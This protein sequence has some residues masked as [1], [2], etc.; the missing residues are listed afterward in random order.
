MKSINTAVLMD[1]I[2]QEY[3]QLPEIPESNKNSELENVFI[4]VIVLAETITALEE[5]IKFDSLNIVSVI[6][7]LLSN[8]KIKFQHEECVIQAI[9]LYE[10]QH[11]SFAECLKK[12]MNKKAGCQKELKIKR[13]ISI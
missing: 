4:N 8:K 3:N 10:K 9:Y 5:N 2:M 13:K 12:M 7:G 11:I 6:T 1:Y